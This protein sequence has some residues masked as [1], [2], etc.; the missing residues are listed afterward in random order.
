MRDRQDAW[1]AWDPPGRA[2]GRIATPNQG[3]PRVPATRSRLPKNVV[4][5]CGRAEVGTPRPWR[6][7]C[8]FR[9]HPSRRSRR[10]TRC[11]RPIPFRPTS[12]TRFRRRSSERV[13]RR[14]ATHGRAGCHVQVYVGRGLRAPV[15][16]ASGADGTHDRD[17]RR[18]DFVG[19]LTG[20]CGPGPAELVAHAPAFVAP[21]HGGM[22]T[23]S[24]GSS[25]E[26]SRRGSTSFL[27]P[28]LIGPSWVGWEPCLEG[29]LRV[30]AAPSP[31]VRRPRPPLRAGRASTGARAE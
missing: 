7:T 24:R 8:R 11:R 27:R 26:P 1:P 2:T 18:L 10:P 31:E 16:L 30:A 25:K 5:V 12:R 13:I 3:R 9:R 4:P 23:A 29:R 20:E 17:A 15:E 21:E 19:I 14:R 28:V 22:L 6:P